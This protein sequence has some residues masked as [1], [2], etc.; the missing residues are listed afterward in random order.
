MRHTVRIK[1]NKNRETNDECESRTPFCLLNRCHLSFSEYNEIVTQA[2]DEFDSAYDIVMNEDTKRSQGIVLV[3]VSIV[4]LIL[5][6]TLGFLLIFFGARHNKVDKVAIPGVAIAII[7]FVCWN[8][9]SYLGL[10]VLLCLHHEIQAVQL[11]SVSRWVE[12]YHG[13]TPPPPQQLMNL[14]VKHTVQGFLVRHLKIYLVFEVKE[15]QV[16]SD[17]TEKNFTTTKSIKV[18]TP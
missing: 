1:G 5:C 8:V 2:N 17:Q 13:R 10:Y 12:A 3:I 4:V 14:R 7:G 9:L 18:S 6:S 16:V 15:Q 11:H